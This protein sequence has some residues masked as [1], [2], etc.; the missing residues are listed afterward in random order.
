MLELT[1]RYSHRPL[2]IAGMP[3]SGTSLI[4]NLL[5]NHPDF[6]LDFDNEAVPQFLAYASD[7]PKNMFFLNDG[8]DSEYLRRHVGH[9]R[10]NDCANLHELNRAYFTRLHLGWNS[11]L[12]WGSCNP[13]QVFHMELTWRWYP[14]A[15]FVIVQR[16]PRDIWASYRHHRH[17]AEGKSLDSE[18]AAQWVQ[19]VRLL[20]TVHDMCGRFGEDPRVHLVQYHHVVKD[21]EL[22]YRLLGLEA[23]E[24][25]IENARTVLLGRSYG[26]ST[27]EL[28]DVAVN[29]D[30]ILTSRVGRWKR[31]LTDE[32]ISRVE[33]VFP[34]TCAFYDHEVTDCA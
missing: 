25:Y 13:Y 4:G 27:D 12:R 23:P 22:I 14:D 32:E 3:K 16:D 21:P 7:L 1:E 9:W 10:D 18:N 31:D 24:N 5:N 33:G 8:R 20:Q 29:G 30:K 19:Y 6:D 2:F 11:G 15:E 17:Y 28:K 34:M 26:L